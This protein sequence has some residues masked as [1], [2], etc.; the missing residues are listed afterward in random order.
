MANS[1]LDI[2]DFYRPFNNGNTDMYRQ[3]LTSG[4]V[5]H[6]N[7]P[8][9]TADLLGFSDGV[10]DFRNSFEGFKLS[11]IKVIENDRDIAVHISMT[12]IQV[13]NFAEIVPKHEPITFYGFDRHLLTEDLSQIQE[14]WHFE[15]FSNLY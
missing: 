8:G 15:D 10:L 1:K 14:T 3:L 13:K 4:W 11:I 6:P 5:N 9:R 12:G 7:D 2:T